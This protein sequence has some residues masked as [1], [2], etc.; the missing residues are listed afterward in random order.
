LRTC[1]PGEE[2][3]A[4][5]A[6]ARSFFVIQHGT[7]KIEQAMADGTRV[8]VSVLGTGSHFG[9]MGLLEK[10]PRSAAAVSVTQSDI[11]EIGYDDIERLL[12]ADPGLAVHFYRELAR[13]LSS[14]LRLTTLDLSYSKTLNISHF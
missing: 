9:E 1:T 6:E 8:E 2:I 10:H 12:E 13:F 5:G 7:V 3:F 14:R 4:Q 11:V